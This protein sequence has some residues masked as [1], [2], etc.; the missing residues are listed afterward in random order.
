VSTVR[1]APVPGDPDTWDNLTFK[2]TD[3]A[4]RRTVTMELSPKEV[5][6]TVTG[7]D[8]TL[9]YG[10]DAQI[11]LFLV[12]D[13]IGG[14]T[15]PKFPATMLMV[16]TVIV[17]VF[18]IMSLAVALAEVA[19]GGETGESMKNF[20][21]GAGP[22]IV[23]GYALLGLSAVLHAMALVWVNRGALAPTRVLPTGGIWSRL[24]TME[25]ITGVGV[26]VAAVGVGGTLISAGTDLFK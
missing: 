17:G 1:A 3:P 9:V 20:L 15:S 4:G 21:A 26:L 12:D 10:T 14:R 6:T 24:S 2:A 18:I 7:T 19:K 5:K 16:W 13:T 11:R 8:A 22:F 23:T 25:K